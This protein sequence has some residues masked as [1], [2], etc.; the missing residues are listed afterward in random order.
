MSGNGQERAFPEKRDIRNFAMY[1]RRGTIA[2][3]ES[4][5][6]NLMTFWEI[7]VTSEGRMGI[8]APYT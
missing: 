7:L 1:G 5:T 3:T 4:V 6:R 2:G 8:P